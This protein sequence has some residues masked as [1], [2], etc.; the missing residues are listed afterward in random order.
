MKKRSEAGVL[1]YCQNVLSESKSYHTEALG[2]VLESR[3]AYDASLYGNEIPGRSSIVTKDIMRTVNG[4]LPSLV[5][6]FIGN[7]IVKIDTERPEDVPGAEKQESL[8][9][10]Q[11]SKKH[12]PLELMESVGFNVMVDGTVWVMSGWSPKGHPTVEVVPFESVIPDPSATKMDDMRFVIHRRKVSMSEILSNQKW[13]GKHSKDELGVLVSNHSDEYEPQAVDGREDTY[14]PDD[15][16]LELVE[17][18]AYYGYYDLNND[19][20]AEPVLMIWS[21]NKL[22]RAEE[23]PYP[24]G[25]IPFD[26]AIYN[27]IPFSIY[28]GTINDLIGDHQKLRTSMTRG[29]IDNMANSN[30]GQKFIRK[31]SLDAVNF[32]R[33]KRGDPYVELNMP[34]NTSADSIIYDGNFNQLPPDIYK[35]LQ[36]TETDMENLTGITKYSVGSDSRS[37]NQTA[38][39]VSIISSMSQ[40]RLV[41]ITRHISAMMERVFIKWAS[42]NAELV[43]NLSIPTPEGHVQIA[44]AELP[45]D[46]MGITVTTPTEGLK[47]KRQMELGN[48][49][50]AVAPMTGITGPEP[51]IGILMEMANLADMPVLQRQLQE[52]LQ[53]DAGD[54]E[55][56]AMQMAKQKSQLEALKISA[57]AQKDIASA[58]KYRAEAEAK[59]ID[60][61][62]STYLE[63]TNG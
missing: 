14:N 23:S 42:M 40:R 3:S 28:G 48:M 27:K 7:E 58:D 57:E 39:G 49:L 24:F 16:S 62:K 4:A 47:E 8:I 13:Y 2:R 41:Y 18:F 12:R 33:L 55:D 25:P 31:G 35:M 44:G 26:N 61:M 1:S 19:G 60:A 54:K 38:T 10:Y 5:E 34:T 51:M 36:D 37:L 63:D 11:W 43:E 30:N 6:P 17:V 52:S 15:R 29:V 45:V 9:N 56:M 59:R 21:G 53:K 20:I 46:G 50:T 22:L 32:N